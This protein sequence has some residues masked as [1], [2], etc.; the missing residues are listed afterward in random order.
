MHDDKAESYS[1]FFYAQ[2]NGEPEMNVIPIPLTYAPMG[3]GG[4]GRGQTLC[5]YVD[6]PPARYGH[7]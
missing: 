7:A 3:Q 1:A 6:T 5:R 4:A 2:Q